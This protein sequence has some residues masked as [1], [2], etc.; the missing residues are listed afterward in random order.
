M[1]STA[2]VL[3][4]PTC[5]TLDPRTGNRVLAIDGRI[6]EREAT[7]IRRQ[8]RFRPN[9]DTRVAACDIDTAGTLWIGA[10][11]R[12][13]ARRSVNGDWEFYTG[14][15]GLPFDQFT[16]ITIDGDAIWFGTTRGAIR[17][18]DG[19]FAYRNAPRWLPGDRVDAIRPVAQGVEITTD[20]GTAIIRHVPMTLERK[21]AEFERQIAER[22]DREGF[23]SQVYLTTPGDRS[24]W[25]P[26]W[27][28][29]DGL[30][31]GLYA[32]AESFRY[33]ATGDEDAR[34]RA[35]RSIGALRL[36]QDVTGVPGFPARAVW[37]T[38]EPDPNG[39]QHQFSIAGQQKKQRADPLWKVLPHR[40]MRSAD[41]RWYWKGDTSGAEID[42]HMF[43]YATYYD[44][45]AKGEG[46]RD[47]VRR[48]VTSLMDHI[49]ANGY[50]LVDHDG[51][52][53]RFGWWGPR[54]TNATLFDMI[55]RS[56]G[57]Q[58]VLRK[59]EGRLTGPSKSLTLLTYLKTA[60][61]ITGDTAYEQQYRTLIREHH[62]DRNVQELRSDLAPRADYDSV[63]QQYL[64]FDLLLRYENEQGLRSTYLAG[65]RRLVLA[66]DMD[67]NPLFNLVGAS[68][69]Q[70]DALPDKERCV[71][72][73]IQTLERI[74]MDT[75]E[76]TM[77]NTHRK[78][79]RSIW[80]RSGHDWWRN[81]KGK[82]YAD[83]TVGALPIDE[84]VV[85]R[86]PQNPY[87]VDRGRDGLV[88]E[89]P[90]HYLLPYY[91]GKQRKLFDEQMP[92]DDSA[93]LK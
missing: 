56:D 31:T 75:I 24:A 91:L 72:D 51:T 18:Q 37:P 76:Y 48:Y 78:D 88:E 54:Y 32:A 4:Q 15:E 79:L 49:I 83:G 57:L 43:A 3:A 12:G 26:K 21:A 93:S 34:E 44:L 2:H 55:F 25:R 40:W 65:L 82:R 14:D 52:L 9:W 70:D 39:E 80:S 63:Q 13:V 74:P 22:H 38:T 71:R 16:A 27:T 42:G 23:V 41:G 30:W 60:A 61:H 86:W 69:L 10:D 46:D 33:A 7:G 58:D 28:D 5:D 92:F 35:Q 36:L 11:D 17:Y 89:A 81:G 53:T 77:R 87:E 64:L 73:S 84:V 85:L 20:K 50:A 19:V 67:R 90:T 8:I 45:A 59:I 66:T 68:W 1:A 6:Y 62:Y 47:L 29:N